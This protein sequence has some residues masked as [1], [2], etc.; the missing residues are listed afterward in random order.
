MHYADIIAALHKAGHPPS[1][2]AVHLEV[3]PSAVSRVIRGLSTSYNVASYIAAVTHIPLNR[4][5]SD[6]RY[7]KPSRRKVA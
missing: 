4:L 1:K 2:V 6:G 7:R 5:W 3:S